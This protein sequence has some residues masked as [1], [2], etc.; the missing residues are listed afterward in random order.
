MELDH[1]Y[2]YSWKTGPVISHS[3]LLK[4]NWPVLLEKISNLKGRLVLYKTC[5]QILRFFFLHSFIISYF[6]ILTESP[7]PYTY[8]GICL[9]CHYKISAKSALTTSLNFISTSPGSSTLSTCADEESLKTELINVE[10]FWE[11]KASLVFWEMASWFWYRLTENK[12]LY[13]LLWQKHCMD[14]PYGI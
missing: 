1:A 10:K 12:R 13:V 9:T 14:E 7:N 3:P 11:K 2:N 6:T 4:R 8:A 5:L